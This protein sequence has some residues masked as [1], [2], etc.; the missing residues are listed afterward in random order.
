MLALLTR[1]VMWMPFLSLTESLSYGFVWKK[2]LRLEFKRFLVWIWVTAETKIKNTKAASA[3]DSSSVFKASAGSI[4]FPI[5]PSLT[6]IKALSLYDL[7]YFHEWWPS[8]DLDASYTYTPQN[9]KEMGLRKS[10]IH[11][12][13]YSVASFRISASFLMKHQPESCLFKAFIES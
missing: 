10:R 9:A 11:A 12:V 7:H 2:S 1:F 5:Q 4:Y 13:C 3:T 6:F 8:A